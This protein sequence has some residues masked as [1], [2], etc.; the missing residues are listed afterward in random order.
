MSETRTGGKLVCH[1]G[2]PKSPRA[3][4]CLACHRKNFIFDVRPVL[5]NFSDPV[6]SAF[7]WII[8]QSRGEIS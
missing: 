3:S 1:C 8:S 6:R 5:T 4:E 2:Q 7:E